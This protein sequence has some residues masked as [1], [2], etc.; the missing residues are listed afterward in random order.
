M[1]DINFLPWREAELK[2]QKKML[3]RLLILAALFAMMITIASHIFLL[4]QE[5]ELRKNI[6]KMHATLKNVSEMKAR[7]AEMH[8]DYPSPNITFIAKIFS[9]LGKNEQRTTCFTEI[10]ND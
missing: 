3:K 7:V 6:I 5:N 10:K 8:A 1:V 4:Q 9:A 2:Y